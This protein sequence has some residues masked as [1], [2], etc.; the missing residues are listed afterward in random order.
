MSRSD[1]SD[2]SRWR[3][4]KSYAHSSSSRWQFTSVG[5]PKNVWSAIEAMQRLARGVNFKDFTGTFPTFVARRS[6]RANMIC[7]W[8]ALESSKVS[9]LTGSRMEEQLGKPASAVVCCSMTR[10][11]E[12]MP[13][14]AS[15][16]CCVA[17]S[18]CGYIWCLLWLQRN[19]V[20]SVA[21]YS[22]GQHRVS[23]SSPGFESPKAQRP[24][25][26]HISQKYELRWRTQSGA[27]CRLGV[28]VDQ[29]YSGSV[30][31]RD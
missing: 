14:S 22:V 31:S 3:F 24:R 21:R 17:M 10:P 29:L 25:L 18:L 4:R 26:L 1:H 2:A 13:P 6:R 20:T 30:D 5:R 11:I 16:Q 15:T 28:L 9:F 19:D 8:T 23:G 27:Q 12:C 7:C